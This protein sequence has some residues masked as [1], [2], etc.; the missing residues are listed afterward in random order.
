MPGSSSDRVKHHHGGN[1]AAAL[2]ERSET[3]RPRRDRD[4]RKHVVWIPGGPFAM[5]PHEHYPAG[6][7]AHTATVEGFWMDEHPV[8]NLAF[9]RFVKATGHVTFAELPPNPAH[10]PGAKPENLGAGPIVFKR[11]SGPVDV[12]NPYNWWDW[13]AGANWR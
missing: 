7:P 3:S 13:K 11:S 9:M 6:G 12:H 10:H 8:T 2:V 4:S 5:A 1:K